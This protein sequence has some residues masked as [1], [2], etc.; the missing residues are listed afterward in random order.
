MTAESETKER[1]EMR[2]N[3]PAPPKKSKGKKESPSPSSSRVRAPVRWTAVKSYAAGYGI[4][5]A[6]AHAWYETMT[7]YGWCH[8]KSGRPL[9]HWQ[10]YL[11]TWWKRRDDFDP[12]HVAEDLP[13]GDSLAK[14]LIDRN[15][16]LYGN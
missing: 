4:C 15:R 2:R 7:R 16:E 12:V 6:F 9:K 10:S 11:E 3:P 1:T 14:E 13:G 8:P 5:T